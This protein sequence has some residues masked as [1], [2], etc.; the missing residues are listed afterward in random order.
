[1]FTDTLTAYSS[2]TCEVDG[3]TVK[4]F[5]EADDSSDAP[6]ERDDGHG[7]VSEWTTRDKRPGER[8]LNKD[9]GS[10]RFYDF[11]AAV[12]IA[13]VDSWDTEP[14]GVG[15]AGERAVRAVEADFSRLQAWCSDDWHY[16]GV[17]V[18]VSKNG[19]ELTHKYDNALWGIE[20]D[21]EDYLTEV[22]GELLDEAVDA[23]KAKLAALCDCA[24]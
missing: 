13:R 20:S 4:A 14:Y 6:W 23:A 1:M 2:I 11:A 19:I 24:A 10:K 5:C 18:Q 7:P 8:L 22:A 17:C 21:C 9:H 16:V 15:T 12:K 3:F